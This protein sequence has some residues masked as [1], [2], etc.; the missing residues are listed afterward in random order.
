L[1]KDLDHENLLSFI[2]KKLA[3]RE[4][5]Y[6]RSVI[7]IEGIDLDI[8]QLLLLVKSKLNI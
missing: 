6:N 1:I 5:Q 4:K 7:T 8:K 2:G 3:D